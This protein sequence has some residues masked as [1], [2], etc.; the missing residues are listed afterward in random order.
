V[1]KIKVKEIKEAD[2]FAYWGSMVEKNYKIENKTDERIRKASKCYHLAKSL[3]WNKDMD[4]KCYGIFH[5]GT[6][7]FTT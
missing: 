4:R 7:P 5:Q 2:K 6:S 3:L 1:E